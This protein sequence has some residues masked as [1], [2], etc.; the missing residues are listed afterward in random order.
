VR[1]S[2]TSLL[3]C[4]TDIAS[5]PVV[6]LSRVHAEAASQRGDYHRRRSGFRTE[7]L[8]FF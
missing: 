6:R 8:Y 7:A 1:C 5:L 4:W 3:N 2:F